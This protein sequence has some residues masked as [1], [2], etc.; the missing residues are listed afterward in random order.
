MNI[1]HS[2][3][4]FRFA[5]TAVLLLQSATCFAQARRSDQQV[6]T[7]LSSTAPVGSLFEVRADGLVVLSDG[8]SRAGRELFRL[9]LLRKLGKRVKLGAGYVWT[10]VDPTSSQAADEH[11]AVQEL[12]IILPLRPAGWTFS[13]RSQLEERRRENI[14][15]MSLRLR[16]RTLLDLPLKKRRVGVRVWNEYFHELRGTSWSGPAGP[17]V[18]LNFIGLRVAASDRVHLT[19]GYLN[20][21][22]FEEGRNRVSH[23]AALFVDVAF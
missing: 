20:E 1:S 17:S 11:R 3:S 10:H 18:M 12:D 21:I 22:R 4:S 7:S 15:G 5:C 19:P 8:A 16:Q 23:A 2:R 14:Q 6:W 9:M 13:I